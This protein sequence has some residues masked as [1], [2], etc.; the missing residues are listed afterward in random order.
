MCILPYLYFY[1]CIL[2]LL[3][4][5]K[6]IVMDYHFVTVYYICVYIENL[7]MIR[8][9]FTEIEPI[10]MCTVI[11]FVSICYILSESR[12]AGHATDRVSDDE[13]QVSIMLLL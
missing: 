12:L 13:D 5:C 2:K 8:P 10:Y 7:L 9:E 11:S 4:L 1:V 3:V 6:I